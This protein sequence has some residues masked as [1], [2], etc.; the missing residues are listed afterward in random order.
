VAAVA[1]HIIAVAVAALPMVVV[2]VEPL[3][4]VAAAVAGIHIAKTQTY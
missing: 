1:P 4:V 3:M 2:A